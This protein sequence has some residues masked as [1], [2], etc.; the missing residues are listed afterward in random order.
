MSKYAPL[1][2][3]LH[4]LDRDDITLSF[5]E[6]EKIL[7][8][9]LPPTASRF[10][11]YW[12]NSGA[13]DGHPGRLWREAGWRQIRLDL[14]GQ[15]VSF[16]RAAAM[17]SDL[18]SLEPKKKELLYDI[19][20]DAGYAVDEWHRT[21]LG[22]PVVAFRSNPRFCY[23]WSFGSLSEGFALCLWY[24][25]LTTDA[26]GR[27]V[28]DDNIRAT[29]DKLLAISEDESQKTDDRLR[30]REEADRAQALDN[31]IHE[32]Y[33][34]GLPVRVI[35]VE[36]HRRREEELGKAASS[37]ARRRLD[38]DEWYVHAYDKTT[39]HC[40]I[41]RD[42]EPEHPGGVDGEG[43]LEGD[44]DDTYDEIQQRAIK[45]RRGQSRFRRQLLDAY[46]RSCAVT[47][48]RVV[49]L[50]EAAHIVPHALK[51]DD[52]TRNGLLLRA[53]IH[54]LFDLHLLTVDEK[55][56]VHVSRTLEYSE[57]WQYNGKR[58]KTVPDRSEDQPRAAGLERRHQLF[59]ESERE[60]KTG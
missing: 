2:D 12:S 1:A 42:I 11:P 41:V 29:H 24:E 19:L 37:V 26:L 14:P 59:R 50:L 46:R 43:Y 38:L 32:S 54:T 27:V 21:T 20:Q 58:L 51:S 6:I 40:L 28:L 35:V 52:K 23:N 5:A 45:S 3:Y 48:T 34:R 44:D 31:A 17:P 36:G 56:V 4:G 53:D 22:H 49:D 39:G 8:S 33:S 57:Y 15:L 9:T 30:A 60:R 10:R 55:C 13:K 25:G 7:G 47:G 16:A 18:E